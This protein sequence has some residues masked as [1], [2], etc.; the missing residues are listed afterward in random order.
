MFQVSN[1]K[2]RLLLYLFFSIRILTRAELHGKFLAQSSD[3]R[4]RERCSNTTRAH[5]MCVRPARSVPLQP[6][7]KRPFRAAT[8]AL[9]MR[10]CL[11]D[12]LGRDLTLMQPR[13]WDGAL[14]LHERRL[15]GKQ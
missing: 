9:S 15:G 12:E 7:S 5:R 6:D 13:G 11:R 8:C 10:H 2:I 4:A 3:L 1:Q 14:S